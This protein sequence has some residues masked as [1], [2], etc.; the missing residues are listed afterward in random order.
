MPTPSFISAL[1]SDRCVHYLNNTLVNRAQSVDLAANVPTSVIDELGNSGHTGIVTDP[2]EISFRVNALDT[3]LDLTKAITGKIAATTF[4]LPD[5][6]S[7]AIDYVG[8]VRDN[9]GNFFR[10]VYIRGANVDGISFSYNTAGSATEVYDFVA[11]NLTVFD[12]YVLT[13]TYKITA[14][15]VTNTY[16]TLPVTVPEAPVQTQINSYFNGSYL[17]RA[18]R[19]RTGVPAVNMVEGNDYTYDPA[20]KRITTSDLL[21]GDDWTLV[22]YSAGI[23]TGL[24]P[25]FSTTAPAAVRGAYTPLSIGVSTKTLIPRLQS[26]GIGVSFKRERIKQL[27][28]SQVLYTPGSIPSIAGNFS[29][30][31]NDFALKKLLTYGSATALETQFGI[32]QLPAYGAQFDLGL[33]VVIKSP[34]TNAVLKRVTV[35]NIVPGASGMPSTVNGTLT[36]SY[37]WTGKTGALTISST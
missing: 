24:S 9:T 6:V 16:F 14:T 30:L 19:T 21:A 1:K 17:L 31:M 4:A 11:D 33:E 8:V 34:T 25:V 3:G 28:S 23:A 36:E 15:D 10:S 37:N 26:A 18:T 27:G 29:V 12:G 13:K 2:A 20:T 35:P 5:F 32:E 7:A 22:F